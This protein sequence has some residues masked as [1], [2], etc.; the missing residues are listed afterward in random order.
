MGSRLCQRM[1]R[2]STKQNYHSLPE[3]PTLPHHHRTRSASLPASLYGPYHRSTPCP[4][5]RRNIDHCGP[6]VLLKC[7]I[8]TLFYHYHRSR[9]HPTISRTHVPMV[10]TS[11]KTNHRPR[12]SLHFA[13][14][15]TANYASGHST[16]PIHGLSPPNR[17]VI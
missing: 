10:W 3:N 6:R 11:D 7:H 17:W 4:R 15:Q 14:W 1:L 9:D 2:L 16:E 13:F 5:P 8:P 12:P